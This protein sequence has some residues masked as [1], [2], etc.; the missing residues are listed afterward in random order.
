MDVSIC[1]VT[2]NQPAILPQCI[3]ACLAEIK[4]TGL[5]A[6]IIVVDNASSDGYPGRVAGCSSA[7]RIIRN[8]HILSFSA[9]NNKAIRI[10]QGTHVLIL[11]DDA[12]LR[13][14]S[15]GLMVGALDSGLDIGA[16]GPKLLN[17][18]GSVQQHFTNRRFPHL[19][20]CLALV[21]SL[22][23][24]LE[25]RAWTHCIFSLDRDPEC[26]SEAEHLAGACL[27]VRREAL[28]A[29]GLFDEGFH[30]WFEDADLCLRFKKA[31][32]RVRYLAEAQVTHH[33][34]ASIGRIAEPDRVIMF[35]RSQMYYLQKHWGPLKYFLV[36][37]ASAL[38]IL[39]NVLLVV[40]GV[41]ARRLSR[42]ERR[43]WTK[44]YL[45]AARLLLWKWDQ[46]PRS[47]SVGASGQGKDQEA[48]AKTG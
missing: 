10:S 23:E 12:I 19:L 31:G 4:A 22:E 9:A 8:E 33:Q 35:F 42:K 36:R 47:A 44:A 46:G 32:W 17:S 38:V 37:I 27:L 39:F 48:A 1:I 24:R 7:I 16:V 34:S 25:R 15:L 43:A 21:S 28:D 30:Y 2:H 3:A 45:P 5:D 20:N 40:T 6:E 11:N 14:G 18:D 26:S 29:V 13:P 41:R